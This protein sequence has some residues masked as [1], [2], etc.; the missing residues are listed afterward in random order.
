MKITVF[1][2]VNTVS[3]IT[4][5]SP[6]AVIFEIEGNE[7][8]PSFVPNNSVPRHLHRIQMHK[9][10]SGVHNTP[11]DVPGIEINPEADVS[12]NT[13][14]VQDLKTPEHVKWGSESPKTP[15]SQQR[16][17]RVVVPL[18]LDP[19]EILGVYHPSGKGSFLLIIIHYVF[20][21]S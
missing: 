14:D 10:G 7:N 4:S 15:W 5:V 1:Q 6:N 2:L 18:N 12:E 9:V 20:I 8:P 11:E 16:E 3:P 13:S 21:F 17:Q 19:I